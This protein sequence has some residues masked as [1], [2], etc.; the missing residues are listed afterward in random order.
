M[1]NTFTPA[2]FFYRDY[3]HVCSCSTSDN[4][5]SVMNQ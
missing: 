1:E 2:C 3:M 4:P 5:I